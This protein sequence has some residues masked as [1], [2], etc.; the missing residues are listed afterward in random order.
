MAVYQGLVPYLFFDDAGAALDWYLKNFEFQEL[1]RW[2]DAEGRVHNAEMRAGDAEI[3]LDGS[4]RRD[5][6]STEDQRP[7]WLGVWV[8]DLDAVFAELQ[9]KGIAQEP[10]VVREFGVEMLNVADP[11]GHLWGFMRR[12]SRG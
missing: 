8:K 11:F 1:G 10:P 7:Q 9:A 6:A 5:F 4:G 2:A 12:T 3:W